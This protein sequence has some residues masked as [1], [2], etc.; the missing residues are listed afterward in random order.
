MAAVAWLGLS[1]VALT[2]APAPLGWGFALEPEELAASARALP[3]LFEDLLDYVKPAGHAHS[4]SLFEA[5][6]G[7]L[8]ALWFDGSREG[9]TDVVIGRMVVRGPGGPRIGP[10]PESLVSA[11]QVQAA[12][13]PE[14][15]LRKLGNSVVAQAPGG[16]P[17]LFATTVSFGG[18]A[19]SKIAVM[20]LGAGLAPG[21]AA[22]HLPLSPVMNRSAL[23][24]ANPILFADGTIGLPTYHEQIGRY[25]ELLRLSPDGRLLAQVRMSH[26]M[27]GI[28][29]VV[30]PLDRLRAVAY[31]RNFSG[32]RTFLLRTRTA[33]GG[34]TW[35]PL[36]R[37][38]LASLNSP[39]AA[40]RLS[41]GAVVV[42][43]NDGPERRDRLV[44]AVSTDQGETFRTIHVL[45]DG[46]A[47]PG[48]AR[49][50]T[51]IRLRDGSF[52]LAFST[53]SRGGIRVVRF[54]EAWVA[55][56]LA[57]AGGEAR[58]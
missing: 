14:Q 17:L 39:A 40:A 53:R 9:A 41:S 24:R 38:A 36:E 44:L 52:A 35:S 27:G 58:P 2:R 21:P 55:Q 23:V 43:Y 49:Y 31:L 29:P 8:S 1:A 18:W 34:R 30:V 4:P 42:V 54:T 6:D 45:E 57:R 47:R 32:D 37:T 13:R 48:D 50:P 26:G 25:G 16:P 33:D 15:A 22:R 3:P 12:V 5:E 11:P 51:L 28:Q 20:P 56:E 46:V 19:M 7:T 10:A